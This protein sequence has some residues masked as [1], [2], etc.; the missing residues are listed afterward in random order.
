[1]KNHLKLVLFFLIAWCLATSCKDSTTAPLSNEIG[2]QQVEETEEKIFIT[3]ETN[4]EWDVTH[5]V[6]HYGFE[7]AR[8][9]F[10]LGPNAIQ[11][12]LNPQ[13]L[14]EG[15]A[16][17][18]SSDASFLVM[19]VNLNGHV[20]AYRLTIMSYHEVVDEQFGDSYVAVAY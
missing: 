6:N 17:Y 20:R 5:A 11:P 14:S 3:D 1:M 15:D 18:P 13:M 16:G 10:G 7:P 12:I 4:K 19:G 2:E 9:Q 8:F